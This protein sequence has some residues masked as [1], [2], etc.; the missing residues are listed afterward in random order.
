MG[1]ITTLYESM[2]RAIW[3]EVLLTEVMKDGDLVVG[4]PPD[5]PPDVGGDPGIKY[6]KDVNV[7]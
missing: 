4:P 1:I 7:G 2:N 6:I 3:V 5:G